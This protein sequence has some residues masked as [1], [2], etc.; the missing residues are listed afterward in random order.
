VPAPT[1]PSKSRVFERSSGVMLIGMQGRAL[2]GT[3]L[4]RAQVGT[5][6][7]PPFK[8]AARVRLSTR[9]VMFHL[10]S[11]DPHRAVFDAVYARLT[12]RAPGPAAGGL[13]GA[14]AT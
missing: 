2:A 6:R 14:R 12:G 8:V 4:S 5:I 10:A 9:R 13:S 3:E 1:S 7:L 11:S